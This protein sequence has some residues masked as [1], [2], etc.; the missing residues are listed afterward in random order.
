MTITRKKLGV[1]FVVVYIA[2]IITLLIG[3]FLAIVLT[4]SPPFSDELSA[5]PYPNWGNVVVF[6]IYS[7]VPLPGSIVSSL[8]S[9]AFFQDYDLIVS[10]FINLL[11]CYFLGY[12]IGVFIE[13]R[14]PDSNN[15]V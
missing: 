11:F 3:L 5:R 8:I 1:I 13:K 4:P 12:F 7:I 9:V 10:I 2:L 6:M 14:R 15:T